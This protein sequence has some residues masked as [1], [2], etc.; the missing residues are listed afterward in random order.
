[1][2]SFKEMVGILEDDMIKNSKKE[3]YIRR[4]LE[5]E[6][7][8]GWMFNPPQD[9]TTESYK[10][11]MYEIF[12]KTSILQLVYNS[13]RAM[14][15]DLSNTAVVFL[16]SICNYVTDKCTEDAEIADERYHNGEIPRA[17][18]DQIY[19]KCDKRFAYVVR[20]NELCDE[21]VSQTAKK[22]KKLSGLPKAVVRH[23]VKC[24]PEKKYIRNDKIGYYINLVTDIIYTD[25]DTIDI[26][27]DD[28]NW[29]NFFV[30]LFGKEHETEVAMYLTLEGTNRI[31]RDWKNAIR[32]REIWD[33]LT[34][35]A[36]EVLEHSDAQTRS[37]T[38]D[39][40]AKIVSTMN[41]SNRGELRVDLRNIDSLLFPNLSKSISAMRDK[42][43]SA[44]SKN[45][46]SETKDV[47]KV[48]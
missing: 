36:L 5:S 47:I 25:I 8:Y 46:G 12:S 7:F 45:N 43:D 41:E 34:A 13:L 15:W 23:A 4:L 35:Y 1:M 38:L 28:I 2:F 32:I 30:S 3:K 42:I 11:Q 16:F 33:S 18:R 48:S 27:D 40:Y 31:T 37:H 22:I 39:L 21:V 44:I 26:M 24:V 29:S 9:L 19:D 17:K 20:I 14:V 6:D 10:T